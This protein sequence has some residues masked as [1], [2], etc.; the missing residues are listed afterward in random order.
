MA[1]IVK[2]SYFLYDSDIEHENKT[3]QDY[4][5]QAVFANLAPYIT[6]SL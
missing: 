3:I 5:V 4:K 2:I 6:L 1:W